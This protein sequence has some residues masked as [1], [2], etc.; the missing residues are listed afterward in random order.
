MKHNTEILMELESLS[1]AAA[2]VPKVN[3][4]TVHDNYFDELQEM[5]LVTSFNKKA[6]EVPVGYFE[7]L[8]ENILHKVKATDVADEL[9]SI[10]ATVASIG[11]KNVYV[12]PKNYFENI[13]HSLKEKQAAKVI[14]IGAGKK[15]AKLA[16]AAVAIGLLGVGI[17]TFLQKNAVKKNEQTA[18]IIREA[19]K[20]I[21][22]NSFDKDFE[23]LADTDLEKYLL[24]NGENIEAAMVATSAENAELPDAM[25]YYLDENT[26]NDFLKENNLKN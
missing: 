20:I 22:S 4:Y 13:Q 5:I 2:A 7:T 15:I 17:F 18:S 23:A 24:Q 11:N 14:S 1:A 10:S 21:T 19:D 26:L 12:T 8:T 9:Q 6:Y 25:D 16:I 3:V